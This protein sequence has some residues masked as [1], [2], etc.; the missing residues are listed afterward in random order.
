MTKILRQFVGSLAA[1]AT[2]LSAGAVLAQ[3]NYPDKPIRMLVAFPAGGPAD[4]T[5]RL[6]A[7]YMT[8]KSV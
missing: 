3:G 6:F 4:V 1:G 2:L 5:A 8:E 7:Q